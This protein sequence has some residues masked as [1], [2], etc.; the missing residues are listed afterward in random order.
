M[1]T[2]TGFESF[3]LIK[4]LVFDSMRPIIVFDQ[5]VILI[6]F[7]SDDLFK[8]NHVISLNKTSLYTR[9]CIEVELIL[10]IPSNNAVYVYGMVLSF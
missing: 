10:E 4:S 2:K 3:D 9:A 8:N 7:R 6:P 1:D 5:N